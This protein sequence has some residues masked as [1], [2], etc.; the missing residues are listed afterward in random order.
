MHGDP[1]QIIRAAG[2]VLWRSRDSGAVEVALVHRPK[3]S[4]WSLPKGKLRRGEHPLVT[5]RREVAEETGVNAVAGR[6]LD[7]EHYDTALG[8]KT[9][10][11]WAMQGPD[12]RFKPTAEVDRLAWL[13]LAEARRRLDYQGDAYAIDAL[14]MLA[15]SAVN[16]SAVLLARNGRTVPIRRWEGSQADRPLDLKGQKQA[17][18]LR[19]ALPA[20]G[21]TRLLSARGARFAGTMQP[22]GADLGL[23]VEIESALGEYEYAEHPRRGLISTLELAS[24]ARTTAICAPGAVIL[25]LLAALAEDADL[26]LGEFQAK[27]G[28]VWALFFSSGRLAAADYYPDL[29]SPRP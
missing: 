4:D 14:E 13:P 27:K 20:F 26:A 8:P 5:A 19:R 7:I 11:Y 9:V 21:P 22:L 16:G 3:Y 1:G 17:E 18:A 28:S 10:E 12:A 15:A 25:H 23:S 2:G 29:T 6:R 24:A